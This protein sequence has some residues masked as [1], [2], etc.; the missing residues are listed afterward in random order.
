M[1]VLSFSL[2]V[3][4]KKYAYVLVILNC[5]K[6]NAV[7]ILL[8]TSVS[9]CVCLTTRIVSSY[10]CNCTAQCWKQVYKG[11]LKNHFNLFETRYLSLAHVL[12]T[13]I[14]NFCHRIWAFIGHVHLVIY[15]SSFQSYNISSNHSMYEAFM[16]AE[17]WIFLFMNIRA[18]RVVQWLWYIPHLTDEFLKEILKSDCIF[19]TYCLL[20]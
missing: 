15:I 14:L 11:V 12:A 18:L 4:V 13:Q 20:D 10:F 9:V 3:E 7:F 16:P 8:V 6:L 19:L 5:P 2:S 1:D 17:D